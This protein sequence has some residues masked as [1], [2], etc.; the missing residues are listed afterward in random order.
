M[1]NLKF[2]LANNRSFHDKYIIKRINLRQP[3][4]FKES[5]LAAFTYMVP[6]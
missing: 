5:N 3:A 4:I 1:P 6:L 2:Y